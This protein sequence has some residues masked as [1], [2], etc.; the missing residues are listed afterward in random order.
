[1]NMKSNPHYASCTLDELL[2]IQ[3]V[4]AEEIAFRRTAG[5]KASRM[6]KPFIVCAESPGDGQFSTGKTINT[7]YKNYCAWNGAIDIEKLFFFTAVEIPAAKIPKGK[8]YK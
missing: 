1:M 5:E 2:D 8:D 7:A 6:T 3:R 4:L